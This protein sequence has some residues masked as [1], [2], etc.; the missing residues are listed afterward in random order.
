M[1]QITIAAALLSLSLGLVPA[2]QATAADKPACRDA[3]GQAVSCPETA[4]NTP[5]AQDGVT[6]VAPAAPLQTDPGPVRASPDR[7]I[8]PMATALCK[9]GRYDNSPQP[10]SA[11]SI[12]GGVAQWLR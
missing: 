1:R 12:H 2:I 8:P 9:D 7:T 6:V 4:P 3:S 11:C 10:T 5:K